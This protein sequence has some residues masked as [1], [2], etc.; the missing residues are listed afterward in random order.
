MVQYQAFAGNLVDERHACEVLLLNSYAWI[1]TSLRTRPKESEPANL[2]CRHNIVTMRNATE[3]G[4]RGRDARAAQPPKSI[5]KPDP[6]FAGNQNNQYPPEGR[7]K[8]GGRSQ[9][10]R[11]ESR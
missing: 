3:S 4:A 5:S 1:T 8:G 9:A 7:G 11:V 6:R 10:L 2:C